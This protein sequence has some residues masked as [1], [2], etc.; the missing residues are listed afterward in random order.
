MNDDI[1]LMAKEAGIYHAFD[2]EGH[3][4]G[5]TDQK[6][7]DPHPHPNDVVYGDKRTVEILERFAAL[8]R[9]D[10]RDRSTRE[11]AYVIAE[12]N[13]VAAWMIAQG[14][15]T[16]HGDTIEGLLEEL[17]REIG[18][19]KA[20]LWIKRINEAV[21]AERKWVLDYMQTHGISNESLDKA[22]RAR[23]NT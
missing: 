20:E 5:L 23:G 13:K 8:V 3:W 18:F 21:L 19:D 9:A 1:I 16:G 17:E 6:L 7:F 11:N 15:A 10:E 2:S 4:D 14:Y 22:I 12:R